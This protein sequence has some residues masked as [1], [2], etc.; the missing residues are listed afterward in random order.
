[1]RLKY[2]IGGIGW[3]NFERLVQTLL[4]AV[5]GPGVTSFGGSKD[6]GRDATYD[7]AAPFPSQYTQWDGHWVFQA[8]YADLET[9]GATQAR[10]ELVKAFGQ[11]CKAILARREG[12]TAAD[13]YVLVTDV[14]LTAGN[15]EK[16][17]KL[18]REA[19]FEGNFQVLDGKDVCQVLDLHPQIRWSFPQLLG[20][21]DLERIVHREVYLRSEAYVQEWQPHLATFV[22][23]TPYEKAL[24]T[25]SEHRFVVLDGPP[26]AGKSTIGAALALLYAAIGYEVVRLRNPQDVFKTLDADRSQFFVADDALGSIA[27][28]PALTDDWSRE[29]PGVLKK[30]DK[31]HLLVWTARTYILEH[32]IAESKLG[33][34]LDDFPGVH[35]VLVEVGSLSELEK[36]EI[37]YNHCKAA[38]LSEE[39]RALVR[40]EARRIVNH[41]SFTPERIRQLAAHVLPHD[42]E[43]GSAK[44]RKVTWSDV[45]AFLASPETR[46]VR[47]Y[48][49]LTESEKALLLTMLDFSAGA[50]T[51]EARQAYEH[52]RAQAAGGFLAFE[53]CVTRLD[54]SFLHRT[55]SYSGNDCLDFQ[56]PSIR[57]MLLSH[58]TDDEVARRKYLELASPTGLAAVIQGLTTS[59]YQHTPARHHLEVRTEEEL[60][61]VLER[62]A[63]LSA[64]VVDFADWHRLLLAADLLIPR[65]RERR[66][67]APGEMDLKA[68]GDTSQGA[69][70]RAVIDTFASMPTFEHNRQYQLGQW[71]AL[72]RIYY[73]LAPYL[74]PLPRPDYLWHLPQ[75]LDSAPAE[76]AALFANLIAQVEPLLVAQHSSEELLNSWDSW[77]RAEVQR[78]IEIGHEFPEDWADYYG[79]GVDYPEWI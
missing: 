29:L 52:R 20:L 36:A 39:S 24:S 14:P 74:V 9:H 31:R 64:T 55:R 18:I 41:P 11:E 73:R 49:K 75:C 25:L 2:S 65:S 72:L 27:L 58:L 21:A 8:K 37:L 69:V 22:R 50:P 7:G 68:F 34:V 56:H 6:D 17:G 3:Y 78:L 33:E 40:E 28:D 53:E 38:P 66:R 59:Q 57:D 43:P 70:L 23:T 51:G 42:G 77:I 67:I 62:V 47:A 4:K 79:E 61:V 48:H 54:H 5:I 19:D 12:R 1:M 71:T 15:R 32:A 45:K 35:E 60:R 26:E 46:W 13:N 16:L 44:A 76:E 63:G 30:L 10:K